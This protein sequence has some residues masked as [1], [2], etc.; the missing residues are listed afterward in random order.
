MGGKK[1]PSQPD[2]AKLEREADA[3]AAVKAEKVKE[4]A[5]EA[6]NVATKEKSTDVE[7]NKTIL[8]N[9]EAGVTPVTPTVTAPP[10]APITKPAPSA[11]SSVEVEKP[12]VASSGLTNTEAPIKAA[13]QKTKV[14]KKVVARGKSRNKTI[15]SS[16]YGA[17]EAETKKKTLLGQ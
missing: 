7:R 14:A 4:T 16:P 5:A 1:E 8:S 2:Y 17:D 15:L 9:P 11:A 12:P 6:A 10:E 13:V 3:R